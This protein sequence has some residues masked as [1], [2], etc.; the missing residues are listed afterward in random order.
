MQPAVMAMVEKSRG[1]Q[2]SVVGTRIIHL[3]TDCD[4]E[5]LAKFH[6]NRPN[7]LMPDELPTTVS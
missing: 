2:L 5:A 7:P 4:S 6:R 1:T 3:C